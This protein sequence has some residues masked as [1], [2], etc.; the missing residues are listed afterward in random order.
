[1]KPAAVLGQQTRHV[2]F[3]QGSPEEIQ[4]DEHRLRVCRFQDPIQGPFAIDDFELGQ[5]RMPGELQSLLPAQI[6]GCC[7]SRDGS[8]DARTGFEQR[9][10]DRSQHQVFIP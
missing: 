3:G 4:F 1:M 2:C 5:V 9:G 6:A 10:V 7:E 8:F